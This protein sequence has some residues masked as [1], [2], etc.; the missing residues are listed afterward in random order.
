MNTPALDLKQAWVSRELAH[1]RQLYRAQFS[2]DGR[3]IAAVGQDKL[4]HIWQLEGGENKTTLDAHRAWVSSMAFH[5]DDDLLFT[6]DYHGIIHC[7]N[8]RDP[9]KGPR[10][11]IPDADR[12][13]VRA[14]AVTPDGH[15]LISAGDDRV[16]KVWSTKE[17]KTVAH[18]KGHAECVFS[19]AISPDGK[20]LVSG[21]LLGIIRQWSIGD[22]W[23]PVRELD[24]T[25][26]HT[27]GEDFLADVGGVRSF[28]F[29]D[30]GKLLAAGGMKEAQ[31]NA[32]CPGKPT[33][34]IYDW[35]SGEKTSELG[36]NG[37]SDGPFNA[38][39]FLGD[40]FLAGH[41]EQLHTPSELAFWDID[42][43][44]PL[45][46]L[47]NHSAYDLSLHPDG[48]QLLAPC[49]VSGGSTGN[50]V[51]DRKREDYT[52]NGSALR[53]FSLF[54]KPENKAGG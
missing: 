11:T 2:P 22:G 10:W 14:L 35:A 50:G 9:D 15:H 44:E 21:D 52:P 51:R 25:L 4:V 28:A 13:N 20:H 49:Y 16:V 39:R 43:P 33:V 8:Y 26:L 48:R 23:K 53:I 31:S 6:A 40:K 3:S 36:I 37:K 29:S 42:Q 12:G 38:L 17:G 24:A 1:D 54:A 46:S 41:T 45:H 27:R 34:L 32:F 47:K 5:P 30:D 18:L 19:L 7:W